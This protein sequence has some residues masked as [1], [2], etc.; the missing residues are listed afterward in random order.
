[1]LKRYA[2]I[3]MSCSAMRLEQDAICCTQLTVGLLLLNSA[4]RFSLRGPQ[5]CSIM[6][7]RMTSPASSRSEL[8]IVPFGLA[9]NTTFAVMSGGYWVRNTVGG[10]SDSSLNITPPTP[11]LDVSTTP[12]KLGHPTTNLQ[13]CVGRVVDSCRIVRQF[14]MANSSGAFQWK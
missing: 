7:Q 10:H 13:H 9:T 12:T 2:R 8:V 11:W 1:M 6:S 5:T 3:R 14:V 4:M